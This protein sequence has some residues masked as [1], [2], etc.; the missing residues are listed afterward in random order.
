MIEQMIGEILIHLRTF[1][2]NPMF[3]VP[4]V[5]VTFGCAL[6]WFMLA[7]K[8]FQSLSSN[9]VEILWKSHKQFGRCIAK[10]FETVTKRKRIV[11]YKCQCG[12]EHKQQRPIINFGK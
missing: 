2:T 1:F 10:K 12:Y 4:T 3:L 5:W 6:S 11:G 7:A 8:K 9:D